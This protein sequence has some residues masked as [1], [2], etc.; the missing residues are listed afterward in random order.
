MFNLVSITKSKS[1]PVSSFDHKQD[2]L[3]KSQKA[4]A[5]AEAEGNKFKK[6]KGKAKKVK[7]SKTV[8]AS[9]HHN[10]LHSKNRV[11]YLRSFL[12]DL[13]P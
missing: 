4:K 9:L 2:G 13:V 3:T 10:N 5:L 12:R 11:R 7:S 8:Q 6:G 1:K